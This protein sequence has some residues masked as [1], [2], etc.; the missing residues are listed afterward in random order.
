MSR[1]SRWWRA[2]NVNCDWRLVTSVWL[3][4]L[5]ALTRKNLEFRMSEADVAAIS[6]QLVAFEILSSKFEILSG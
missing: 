3:W 6:R 5:V 1:S 2:A 4:M